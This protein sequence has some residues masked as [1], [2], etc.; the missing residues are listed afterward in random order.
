MRLRR[1]SVRL[2]D[3]GDSWR[4][5]QGRKAE[6]AGCNAW[7]RTAELAGREVG[8]GKAGLAKG[9]DGCG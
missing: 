6:L 8:D 4:V 2:S 9:K 5:G 1:R 7:N 3:E